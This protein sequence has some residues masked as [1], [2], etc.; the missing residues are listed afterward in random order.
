MSKK[1]HSK[2]SRSHTGII[3]GNG[4]YSYTVK[5]GSKRQNKNKCVYYNKETQACT[6]TKHHSSYCTTAHNCTV[7]KRIPDTPENKLSNYD[8]NY[9]ALP[10]QSG[11][12]EHDTIGHISK[13]IGTPMHGTYL[14]SEGK[15]RHKSRCV[16]YERIKKT[17]LLLVD[18]CIGSSHCNKYKERMKRDNK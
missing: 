16:F 8:E 7:Y 9:L 17:C 12:H 15:R 14:K 3:H 4:L 13:D 18:K 1:K 5:S 10:L 2:Q 11:I 6:N